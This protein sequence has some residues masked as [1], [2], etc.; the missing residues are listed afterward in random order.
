VG[1]I[2]KVKWVSTGDHP[3]T[4]V[5]KGSDQAYARLSLAREPN[6]KKLTTT[7]GM[8]LKFLRD[9]VDSGDMVAMIGVDGHDSWNFFKDDFSNHIPQSS[10]SLLPL[11][12]K[13]SASTM[14]V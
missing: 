2:A 6:P 11:L 4:G 9:G 5:F 14:W 10:V 3:Y 1:S 8:G 13:F 12:K 7:P